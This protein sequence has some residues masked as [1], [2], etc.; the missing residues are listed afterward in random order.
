MK[1]L[2]ARQA[3]CEKVDV[4]QIALSLKGKSHKG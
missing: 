2:A 1:P 3:G 4:Q